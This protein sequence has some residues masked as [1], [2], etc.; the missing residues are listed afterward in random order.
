MWK[1]RVSE[2]DA[3]EE[4]VATTEFG[5]FMHTNKCLK[6]LDANLCMK[7][8]WEA[9]YKAREW[10]WD[11]TTLIVWPTHR[12][13]GYVF[14]YSEYSENELSICPYCS[15][16]PYGDWL[17]SDW[18]YSVWTSIKH[19]KIDS[20]RIC[21]I[22]RWFLKFASLSLLEWIFQ[23][24]EVILYCFCLIIVA[25]YFSFDNGVTWSILGTVTGNAPR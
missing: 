12:D 18:K 10:L 7:S 21:P 17:Q 5:W 8:H 24:K 9:N 15:W 3:W 16:I 23:L 19:W 25:L 14:G 22:P 1:Q 4:I 2:I 20:S 13:A 6:V 11:P